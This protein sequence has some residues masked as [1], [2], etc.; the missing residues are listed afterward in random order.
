MKDKQ[1]ATLQR[2]ALLERASIQD[3][4]RTVTVSLS[5]EAP[6]RTMFGNETLEHSERAVDMSRDSG[7]GF[8]LL[9]SH[10]AGTPIGRVRGVRIEGG[11]LRGEATFS[12]NSERAQQIWADVR[13][14]FLDS[15]S[16]GYR[17]DDFE[18]GDGD[19]Y[20]VTR[21]TPLEASIVA[22]PADAQVGVG[23]NFK[24][25]EMAED[26][27]SAGTDK[28]PD[29]VTD[30][31][32]AHERAM[33][34]GRV[35]GQKLELERQSQVR[36]LFVAFQGEKYDALR[37][38]CVN[39]PCTVDEARKRL[40]D[41][42][43]GQNAP[44]VGS[45]YRQ[46]EGGGFHD[47]RTYADVSGGE[48]DM[49]KW[50]R[51]VLEALEIRSSMFDGDDKARSIVLRENPFVAMTLSE[52]ARDYLSRLGVSMRGLNREGIAG[53]AFVRAG[54]GSHGTS[55]FASVLADVANKSM[56]IGWTQAE[57]TWSMIT[58]AQSVPDFKPASLV[59]LSL[60]PELD[61]VLEGGEFKHK[62]IED[63]HEQLTLLT[64]GNLFSISRQAIIN[65]DMSA[66]TA[67]PGN[68]GG[69]AN[70]KIG[71]LVYNILINNPV[72]T[73]DGVALFDAGHAN[74]ASVGAA[75][76]LA[77][78]EAARVAMGLQKDPAGIT[79]G[80][81]PT[82]MMVPLELQGTAI[83]LTQAEYDPASTAGTL[84]PNTVRET[85]VPVADHRL[86]ANSATEWY[87]S[88]NPNN[89]D[90]LI[91][92][93][94]NGQSTPFLDSMNGWTVDGVEYKVRIDAAAIPGDFRGLYRNA[95]A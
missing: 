28:A 81:R 86:S 58:R 64:Y 45:D 55:D 24:G 22:V 35:E 56:L 17:I 30:L 44:V 16:I 95:G 89:S 19:A 43:A 76:A 66:F 41:M 1:G 79:I 20:T 49:E 14:G 2:E 13:D 71:D 90:A 15:V 38:A 72:M 50:K 78:V 57:E 70:R 8:P 40:L 11:K 88:S 60:F 67:I 59:A 62:T 7:N 84:A 27:K 77:T 52:M 34:A 93:F 63:V 51:G 47:E 85:Y 10:D 6:V 31:T 26:V 74:V 61:T 42:V 33:A 32:A 25:Y 46:P 3:D 87:M 80:L 73:Q 37:E 12:E 68:M 54:V 83:Q 94:L 65:D 69:A 21:W 53:Q 39:T 18:A 48:T 82:I 36:E 75:P 92:G 23:R 4:G 9:W 5:S 91:V 29:N